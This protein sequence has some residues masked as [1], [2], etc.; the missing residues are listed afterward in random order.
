MDAFTDTV[1]FPVK[2]T[3]KKKKKIQWQQYLE[4]RINQD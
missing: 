4:L 2:K 1:T 3:K